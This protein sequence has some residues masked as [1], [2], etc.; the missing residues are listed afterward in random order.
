[1]TATGYSEEMSREPLPHPTNLIQPDVVVR[2][3]KTLA[4]FK[5]FRVDPHTQQFSVHG[6]F[7][8]QWYAFDDF[9]VM[10]GQLEPVDSN[11][12]DVL[13]HEARAAVAALE[14][15]KLAAEAIKAREDERKEAGLGTTRRKGG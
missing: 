2:H 12:P 15:Q 4:Q 10:R 11:D 6:G 8:T 1:M 13:L 14:A 5:V 3:R 9:D 7:R